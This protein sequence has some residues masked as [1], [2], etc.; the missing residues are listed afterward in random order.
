ML[1]K[2]FKMI[3]KYQLLFKKKKTPTI[4]ELSIFSTCLGQSFFRNS[5]KRW[6]REE[7]FFILKG[8]LK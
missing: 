6:L 8:K 5:H 1:E 7:L 3:L 2:S 4:V